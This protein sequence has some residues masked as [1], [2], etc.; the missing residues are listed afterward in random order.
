MTPTEQK[1]IKAEELCRLANQRFGLEMCI[2]I[3]MDRFNCNDKAVDYIID[4]AKSRDFKELTAVIS[5][6]GTFGVNK[7]HYVRIDKS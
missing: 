2:K 1:I 3:L 6:I 7:V 5:E 4:L